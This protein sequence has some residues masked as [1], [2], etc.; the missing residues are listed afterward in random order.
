M[1]WFKKTDPK[2]EMRANNKIIRK[3]NRELESDRRQMQRREKELEDQIRMYAKQG[4]KDVCAKLAK[5]LVNMRNQRTKSVQMSANLTGINAQNTHMQSMS[6]MAGIMGDTTK[7][8]QAMDK[9]N[10]IS[11]IVKNM[12]DFEMAKDKME[13]SEELMNSTLDDMFNEPGDE[14]EQNR[15]VSQVLDEIGIE[16]NQ[17]LYNLPKI[18]NSST[19]KSSLATEDVE[20]MLARLRE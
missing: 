17:Q 12:K 10:P 20:K 4:Q 1:D 19:E 11:S 15:I 6:R 3:A 18:N 16:M 9:L 2:E 7:T 14:E 8:M 5:Q 13:M